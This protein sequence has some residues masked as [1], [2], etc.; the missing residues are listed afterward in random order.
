MFFAFLG[1]E[2]AQKCKKHP[3]PLF[4]RAKRAQKGHVQYGIWIKIDHLIFYS[5]HN[6]PHA[7]RFEEYILFLP[8][9]Q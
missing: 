1:G 6:A 8:F 7:L 4:A 3:P 9:G 2:A 5:L